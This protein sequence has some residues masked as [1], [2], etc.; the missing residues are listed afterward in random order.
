MKAVSRRVTA[1]QGPA[2]LVEDHE[3]GP[4][5]LLQ[6]WNAATPEE[7]GQMQVGI[8]ARL[9]DIPRNSSTEDYGKWESLRAQ[10]SDTGVQ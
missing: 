1:P 4:D 3:I 7:R 5:T 6:M 9:D 8:A 10:I 2:S